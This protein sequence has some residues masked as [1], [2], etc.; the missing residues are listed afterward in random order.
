VKF[1]AARPFIIALV[2]GAAFEGCSVFWVRLAIHGTPMQ[3]AL[4]SCVQALAQVLGIG[5]SVRNWRVAPFFIA[6]YGIGSYLAML[7]T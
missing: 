4:V 1:Q 3:T 6:G 7:F 2:S 5:E